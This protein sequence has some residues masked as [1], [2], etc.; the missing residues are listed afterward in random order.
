MRH[1]KK[2]H[3]QKVYKMKG[4]SKKTRKNHLGGSCNNNP[5]LNIDLAYS[6]NNSVRSYPSPYLAY[7]GQ[8]GGKTNLSCG[9]PSNLAYSGPNFPTTINTN[10]NTNSL[11]PA[12]PST[13]PTPMSQNWLN[14]QSQQRGGQ[15]RKHRHDCKCSSCKKQM[16]Q[17]GGC[18]CGNSLFQTGGTALPFGDTPSIGYPNGLLG[19]AWTP[20]T[21]GWPGVDGVSGDRNYLEY[22]TYKPVDISRQMV[23]TGAN[24]PFSVG[25]GKNKNRNQQQT[26]GSNFLYQDMINLGR[27]FSYNVG[28]AYNAL[29]GYASPVN[30]LPW[31]D[32]LVG[33]KF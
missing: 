2:S 11:N 28:S 9:G 32:Q 18:G 30:P 26:G 3:K 7:T 5:K 12:Y 1:Y 31:K 29:N 21:S 27:Q 14:S 15:G 10:T 19:K 24:P 33:S 22:N 20:A 4:C 16:Y 23:A 6:T 8:K 13:G 25:G 17:R